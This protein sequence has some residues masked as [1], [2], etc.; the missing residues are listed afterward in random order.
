MG[1]TTDVLNRLFSNDYSLLR[2]VRS[3]GL[4]LVDRAPFAKRYFIEQAA[5][6]SGPSP[7][8]LKGEPI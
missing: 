4:S 3:F 6:L 5:G 2:Q 8:L 1:I 7:R